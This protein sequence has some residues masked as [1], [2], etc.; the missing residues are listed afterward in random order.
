MDDTHAAPTAPPMIPGR[1]GSLRPLVIVL[2]ALGLVGAALLFFFDP[3]QHAFYPVCLFKKMTGYDCPGCGG[4]RAVHQLLRGDVWTA[5]QLNALAVL[6]VPALLICAPVAWRRRR[7]STSGG[8]S[9]FLWIWFVIA[10]IV[11]FGVVRNLPVWP[12]GITPR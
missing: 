8:S 7:V 11:I 3:A 2:A 10:T 5:V 6:A 12:F 1:R 9:R 4:L